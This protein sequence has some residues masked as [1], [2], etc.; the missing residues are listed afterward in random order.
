MDYVAITVQELID[1]LLKIEDRDLPVLAD[2][3]DCWGE[4][5]R[6]RIVE[7]DKGWGLRVALIE[8][9]VHSDSGSRHD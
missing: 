7:K 4:A 1:E 8:R 3:C 6:V 2:G 5:A 9:A